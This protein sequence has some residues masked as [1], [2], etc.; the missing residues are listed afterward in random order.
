ML[1]LSLAGVALGAPLLTTVSPDGCPGPVEIQVTGLS[2]GGRVAVLT[3]PAEGD[4]F[5]VPGCDGLVTRVS[6]SGLA[7]RALTDSVDG[8]FVLTPS[9]PEGAC[10]LVMQAIDL[11]ACTG[12]NTMVVGGE[13]GCPVVIAHRGASGDTPENTLAA[14]DAAFATGATR[15]EVDVRVSADEQG[16][17]MHDVGLERTTRAA[18][19][20]SD[21]VLADLMALD[22]G[23]WRG[24][25]WGSE[26]VPSLVEALQRARDA[27]GALYLDVKTPAAEVVADAVSAV[28]LPPEQLFLSFGDPFQ[29]TEYVDVLPESPAAWWGGIPEEYGS[30]G[31][32]VDG[33]FAELRA[34]NVVASEH[35]WTEVVDDPRFVAYADDV[36]AAG[37]ELWTFTVNEPEAMDRVRAL[38]FDAV[39]TDFPGVF[40]E[41]CAGVDATPPPARRVLGTWT[42]AGDLYPSGM[43]SQLAAWGAALPEV[44]TTD[45]LGLPDLPGGPAGVLDYP[46]AGPAGGMLVFPNAVHVGPGS[47]LGIN[48]WTLVVDLY[49]PASADGRWTPLLQTNEANL[50]D[51]EVYIHPDGGVG[52]LDQY[53][54]R[55][56][57]E[58]WTRLVVVVDTTEGDG[59]TMRVYQDGLA[60]GEIRLIGGVDSRFALN[61]TWAYS[62]AL[63]FTDVGGFTSDVV[64]S[65]LQL[66]ERAL[67]PVEA[68]ALGG[69]SAL[70]IPE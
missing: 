2:P 18:G 64:V 52:I 58:T 60:A 32:D 15:A 65:A 53:V 46:D 49:R 29:L 11:D 17:L 40:L 23:S 59:G 35:P 20:A 39:E 12:S 37:L 10:G 48:A 7:L 63:L 16:F 41:R 45:L 8:T 68:L 67:E 5:P 4:G 51:A 1:V 22:A 14:L 62:E 69:P 28:G 9:V 31:F 38:G 57:P 34:A 42:F 21:R 55:V 3:A 19:P 30:P 47:G 25:E 44:S 61:S 36:R 66:H 24:A 56:L 27:G 6:A 54:G 13:L 43:G 70:G 26:R 50:N 33:W